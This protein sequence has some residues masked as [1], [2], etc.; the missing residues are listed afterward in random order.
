ME[1]LRSRLTAAVPVA[2]L[3]IPEQLR[4][5]RLITRQSQGEYARMCGVAPRL[6]A[7]VENGRGNPGLETLKKLVRPFGYTV[8]V[9]M[10]DETT[11]RE[12]ALPASARKKSAQPE[13]ALA[14]A[15]KASRSAKRR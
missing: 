7:D 15:I 9:V 10:S 1:E 4:M 12:P 8:G 11:L 6:L 5:M 2:S 14:R 13:S 3:G